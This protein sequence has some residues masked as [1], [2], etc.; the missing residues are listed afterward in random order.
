MLD[1]LF[2]GILPPN[3]DF[4][5]GDSRVSGRLS[6]KGLGRVIVPPCGLWSR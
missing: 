1:I 6:S 4:T 3:S 5:T 2:K